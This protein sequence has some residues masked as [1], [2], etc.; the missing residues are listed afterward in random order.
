MFSVPIVRPKYTFLSGSQA[1]VIIDSNPQMC[2]DR[3]SLPVTHIAA[4]GLR[5]FP[6][7]GDPGVW[8]PAWRRCV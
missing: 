4:P 8:V 1:A 2:Q 3:S 6:L 5:C 7:S